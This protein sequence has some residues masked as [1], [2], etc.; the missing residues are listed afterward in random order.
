MPLTLRVKRGH[1]VIMNGAVLQNS[2]G[3]AIT[4]HVLNR[5]TVLLEEDL[6]LPAEAETPLKRL[7]LCTQMMYLEPEQHDEFYKLF[8]ELSGSEFA[9]ALRRG[10][11]DLC[12]VIQSAV[13]AVGARN[14][15][16][17]MH[18]LQKAIGKPGKERLS[19]IVDDKE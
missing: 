16:G 13:K 19:K 3:R 17:A 5:A 2:S 12:E 11:A 9:D 7:Y 10:D 14:F 18:R 15:A 8:I 4:L 6:M 1:R